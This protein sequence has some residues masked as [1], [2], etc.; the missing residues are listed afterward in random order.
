MSIYGRGVDD[1]TG[2]DQFYVEERTEL[3][4]GGFQP[5]IDFRN[6]FSWQPIM[7][8]YKGCPKYMAIGSVYSYGVTENGELLMWT[9]EEDRGGGEKGVSIDVKA[10]SAEARDGIIGKAANLLTFGAKDK[11]QEQKK[12]TFTAVYTNSKGDMCIF[13]TAEGDNYI[14]IQ[15][16]KSIELL[17]KLRR[18]LTAIKFLDAF[19]EED[20]SRIRLLCTSTIG[21]FSSVGDTITHLGEHRDQVQGEQRQE[22]ASIIVRD[23][24]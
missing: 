1:G 15:R 20:S 18:C 16:T 8:H 7:Q 14:Y 10:L 22:C 6:K 9:T 19:N 12:L 21:I 13:T 24:R 11:Q 3:K 4:Q 5:P 2:D 23:D 17:N